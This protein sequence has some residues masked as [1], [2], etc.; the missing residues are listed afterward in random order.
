M[1]CGG[2]RERGRDAALGGNGEGRRESPWPVSGH[3]QIH[4]FGFDRA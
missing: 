3:F 1:E 2:K 4:H